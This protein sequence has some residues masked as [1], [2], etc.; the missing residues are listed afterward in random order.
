[1]RN[2]SSYFFLRSRNPPGRGSLIGLAISFRK[3]SW[4]L[5]GF[6]QYWNVA[7]LTGIGTS[8]RNE[9]LD[10]V[11]PAR[12]PRGRVARPSPAPEA[13]NELAQTGRSGLADQQKGERRRCGTI[14]QTHIWG[15]ER[16]PIFSEEPL[17]LLL[18]CHFPVMPRRWV[19]ITPRMSFPEYR[20]DIARTSCRPLWRSA[21]LVQESQGQGCVFRAKKLPTV[22]YFFYLPFLWVVR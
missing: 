22:T 5:P 21:N 1:V 4:R 6:L 18:V 7:C 14:T 3:A 19:S 10:P 8:T 11:L 20:I 17:E 16:N 9:N 13:R 12:E 2:R 15:I